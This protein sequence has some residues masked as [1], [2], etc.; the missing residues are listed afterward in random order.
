[1]DLVETAT[2]LELDMAF[3][4]DVMMARGSSPPRV[5]AAKPNSNPSPTGCGWL[6]AAGRSRATK[7]RLIRG[8]WEST[9]VNM[10]ISSSV[11]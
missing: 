11:V 5:S 6:K 2:V 4:E 10:Y 7:A 3:V 8:I 1:M 9:C